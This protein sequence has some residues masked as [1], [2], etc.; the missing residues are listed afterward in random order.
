MPW[1]PVLHRAELH[2]LRS[3]NAV[4][5]KALK[6]IRDAGLAGN[7]RR[8]PQEVLHDHCDGL[9]ATAARALTDMRAR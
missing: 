4:A 7:P 6:D 9:Q 2:R 3:E 8:S 5:R 1:S